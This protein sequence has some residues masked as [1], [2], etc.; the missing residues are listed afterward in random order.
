MFCTTISKPYSIPCERAE[1][2]SCRPYVR[3]HLTLSETV[4]VL[5]AQVFIPHS[6][7]DERTQSAFSA[8]NAKRPR[9]FTVSPASIVTGQLQRFRPEV[10]HTA[11]AISAGKGTGPE[12][13]L[14]GAQVHTGRKGRVS[15]IWHGQAL[16]WKELFLLYVLQLHLV[17][18]RSNRVHK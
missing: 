15:T 18:N 2:A 4:A 11:L 1:F 14:P 10:G 13:I 8:R 12:P 16:D 7:E 17:F 6:H 5:F 9:T 3:Q